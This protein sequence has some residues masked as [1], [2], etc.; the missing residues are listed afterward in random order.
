MRGTKIRAPILGPRRASGLVS[1]A[2]KT[3]TS[4]RASVGAPPFRATAKL[5]LL[6]GIGPLRQ[7]ASAGQSNFSTPIRAIDVPELHRKNAA[8]AA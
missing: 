2:Q 8:K 1:L 3:P 6:W 7:L 5:L 4:P